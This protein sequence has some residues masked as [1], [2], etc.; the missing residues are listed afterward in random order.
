MLD[1]VK[2]LAGQ[3]LQCS[4][5]GV[6]FAVFSGS[7]QASRRL[8][9][10]NYPMRDGV[11]IEDLGRNALN[12]RVQGFL[13]GDTCTAQRDLLQ[14]AAE[15]EGPGLLV[16]PRLGMIRAALTMFSWHD[17]PGYTNVIDVDLGFYEVKNILGSTVTTRAHAALG[18]GCIAYKA[19]T[20]KHYKE[21]AQLAF[22]SGQS[23][24]TVTRDSAS[25]WMSRFEKHYNAPQI[26]S[27]AFDILTQ[28]GG[29]YA[30]QG[31]EARSSA[32]ETVISHA[33]SG[34]KSALADGLQRIT[35]AI[36]PEI[37]TA[38]I[39]AAMST[40]ED[41]ISD[42]G[43]RIRVLSDLATLD[44]SSRSHATMDVTAAFCRQ[45]ALVGIARACEAWRPT[46]AAEAEAMRAKITKLF[47]AE[48]DRLADSGNDDLSRATTALRIDLTEN[49][50]SRGAKLPEIITVRRNAT[51]PALAL[52]Q[53]V[54]ASSA[55]VD[56][57]IRRG[58][59]VHPAFMPL[60]ME[61]LA[62]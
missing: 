7:G 38:V 51:M 55:K 9:I 46:S 61:A 41:V 2:R 24:L 29:R 50:S 19:A 12:I 32:N 45:A 57:M 58:D 35:A 20:T 15:A 44:V 1:N 4:F 23:S 11:W 28:T 8:A 53:Q 27:A 10:H 22:R 37:V 43:A 47:D 62:P 52:A 6:P 39:D 56:D 54:Y 5:R 3:Y 40:F 30:I 18:A 21:N 31:V 48:A 42:P 14:K 25:S 34:A 60:Q 17:R 59:P 26:S 36:K 49:L 33:L 13:C 16:H